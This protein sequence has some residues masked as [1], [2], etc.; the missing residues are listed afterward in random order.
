MNCQAVAEAEGLVRVPPAYPLSDD[1][2]PLI[3]RGAYQKHVPKSLGRGISRR[4]MAD[5]GGAQFPVTVHPPATAFQIRLPDGGRGGQHLVCKRKLGAGM[6][7][8]EILEADYPA[9]FGEAAHEKNSLTLARRKAGSPT[10]PTG[11]MPGRMC[12][13]PM[14]AF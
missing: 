5:F 8:L 1:V 3:R 2:F 6:E 12:I 7:P 14:A 13:C 11:T 4:V 9:L 10:G